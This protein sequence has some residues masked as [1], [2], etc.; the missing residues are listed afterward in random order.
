LQALLVLHGHLCMPCVDW[1][2]S[3]SSVILCGQGDSPAHDVHPRHQWNLVAVSTVVL[4]T[5]SSTI[6]RTNAFG[7]I[8][9]RYVH[10]F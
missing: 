6:E 9:Q 8:L 7:Q 1:S 2:H 3:R 4:E 5:L 10:L